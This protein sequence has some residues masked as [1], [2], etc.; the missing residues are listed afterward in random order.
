MRW[1]CDTRSPLL[2]EDPKTQGR[3]SDHTPWRM[4]PPEEVQ[5]PLN[6]ESRSANSSTYLKTSVDNLEELNIQG[7]QDRVGM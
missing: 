7:A 3:P 1:R 5:I 4:P 2:L 6:L